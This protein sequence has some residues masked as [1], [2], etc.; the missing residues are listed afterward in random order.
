[1]CF[2]LEA[3][4]AGGIVISSI[5]VASLKKVQTPN[6]TALASVP[7]VFGVQ[8]FAEGVVWL[9]I[10]GPEYAHLERYGTYTFLFIARVLWPSLMPL[11]VLLMEESRKRKKILRVMLGMGL[12]V[13]LYYSYCIIF[14]NVSPNIAGHHIQ[15][16]SDFPESLAVPVFVIYF[17]AGVPPLFVSSIK[18]TRL[19]GGLMFAACLVTGIFYTEYLTSVWCFFAAGVSV[20]VFWI[21]SAK[22]LDIK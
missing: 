20:V 5:G 4:V 7:L 8:Q 10:G 14:M 11:A 6:Q 1:M 13:S 22:R 18:R 3:S 9:A 17:L 12:S 16:I 19:L 21:V 2:S 15:Y